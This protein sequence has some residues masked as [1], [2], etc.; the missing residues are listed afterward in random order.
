M[1]DEKRNC[2][3]ANTGT[4]CTGKSVSNPLRHTGIACLAVAVLWIFL[5]L[6]F[7]FTYALN[8]D[9]ALKD[10]LSGTYT[11]VPEAHNIQMLYP[12]SFCISL[13]YKLVPG[14]PWLG[15]FLCAS[16]FGAVCVIASAILRNRTEQSGDGSKQELTAVIVKELLTALCIALSFLLLFSTELVFIQYTVT[17]GFL[18]AAAMV[19]FYTVPA[20]DVSF[21]RHHIPEILLIL[22]AFMLRTEM[23]LFLLPFFFL[24]VLFRWM[25]ENSFFTRKNVIHY[26]GLTVILLGCMALSAVADRAAYGSE[27]W[28]TFRQFFDDRTSVYDFYGIPEYEQNRGFYESI[29][30]DESQYE[31]LVN[32]N[33][34]LDPA[35]DA[36]VM[37]QIAEY[38]ASHQ[39][40]SFGQRLYL[41]VYEYVYR[42]THGQELCFD[43]LVVFGYFLLFQIAVR[44][45]KPAL[46][47]KLFL[48]FSVR[49]ALW[50]F[51]LFRGRAPE[52]ITH[53]LYLMELLLLTL[54]W[55]CDTQETLSRYDMAY[56]AEATESDSPEDRT[57][58]HGRR[59][60][61]Y[62]VGILMGLLLLCCGVIMIRK[63][64]DEAVRREQVNTEWQEVKQY[65]RQHPDVFY[66][67]DVYSTVAYSEKLF[68]DVDS[69]YRNFDLLG[70][71]I[72]KSPLAE[73]KRSY[74]E[75]DTADRALLSGQ[76]HFITDGRRPESDVA[77]IVSYFREKGIDVEPEVMGR[78]GSFTDY[79]INRL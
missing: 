66:Y 44:K 74:M 34:D 71:W 51:L 26:V 14:V 69:S 62:T 78:S 63:T 57:V 54:L 70:G 17:S 9:T 59:I 40:E 47:G 8:D 76:A 19:R 4:G 42:F 65:C 27:E 52:R 16:Q 7:D 28:Q 61:Q 75:M 25:K 41:S 35:I 48:L 6:C 20:D 10:I 33:F 55:W 1:T 22:C 58:V 21:F 73:A 37:H 30:I 50:L 60:T 24:A 38:A 32:Y 13:F 72:A 12:L 39:E 31:L 68:S 11:G 77:H 18:M 23:A 46:S 64:V 67:F 5:A 45:R 29:G 56:S 15:V 36:Q 2:N 53:P 79:R 43:L 3:Q 49:S